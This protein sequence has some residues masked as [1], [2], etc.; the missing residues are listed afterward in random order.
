MKKRIYFN[1][2]CL[3]LITL[4]LASVLLTTI[5]Y[6]VYNEQISN[7]IA[8]ETSYIA[9]ACNILDD[10]MG[11]LD[12]LQLDAN[13]RITL[14]AEDGTVIYDSMFDIAQLENH[15][16]R[17]EVRDAMEKGNGYS[18]RLSDTLKDQNFYYAKALQ[19]GTILRLSGVSDSIIT[20]FIRSLP[21]IIG[22]V[23]AILILCLLLANHM[24]NMI[25]EPI[26]YLDLSNPLHDIPYEELDPL[27]QKLDHQNRQIEK[28]MEELTEQKDTFDNITEHMSEGLIL[29]DRESNIIFINKS[30]KEVL[31]AP[32]MDYM[33]KHILFLNRSSEL[34]NALRT[35]IEGKANTSVI[36][37]ETRYLQLIANPVMEEGV[38]KGAVLFILD[39]TD[40][41]RA[42]NVRKEFSANVSHELKTPLTSISGYAELMVN[43][44][45]QKDDVARFSEKIYK[46]AAR[47]IV[48]VNDII[49]IS[50]LDERDVEDLKE[51]VNLTNIAKSVK[52]RLLEIG[53]ER[54]VS[55][56]VTEEPVTMVAV[57]QMMDELIF[58]LCE[59][60]IK[61]NQE[62][63]SVDVNIKKDDGHII[64]KV[65]DTGIG[66]HPEDQKRIF[67]RFYRVDKSHSKQT[68]GTGLGL[69]IVKH[70][71]EYHNGYIE[72]ESQIDK[73]TT[74]I[75]HFYEE[76]KVH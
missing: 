19:D 49:K 16:S 39:I 51:P 20:T 57:P 68:G 14:I 22:I 36:E 59:N 33:G 61:Y 2:S 34:E 63:G 73:G 17:P 8:D 21:F 52:D 23:I 40:Q 71:V 70:I 25:I 64:I 44:L 32:K 27:L 45:V 50:R 7:E 60:A 30:C 29:V 69:A 62:N 56:H 10:K 31:R 65:Q 6:R 76:V 18:S 13:T 41:Q 11:Y 28:Q 67:E 3:T 37:M 5:F 9:A 42:E 47:L 54:N 24:T 35:A 1:M 58:N 66:I 4:V 74:M 38:I 72:L 75:V 53:K 48:L 46:E 43:G 55:I 26:N 12:S 15:G